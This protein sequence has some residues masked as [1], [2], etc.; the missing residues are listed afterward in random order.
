[1]KGCGVVVVITALVIGVFVGAAIVWLTARGQGPQTTPGVIMESQGEIKA[2]LDS[3]LT[4]VERMAAVLA[5]SAQRGRAGEFVL[6]N[7]LEETGM[8]QHRDFDVQVTTDSARPDVVLNLAGRGRLVIDAKF[9]LD[10]FQ[11]AATAVTEEERRHALAAHARA[12][13][14]HVTELGQRDY[15]SK[16][17]GA[18]NFTVCFV[19]G[20]DLLAAAY[21][22]QPSLFYDAIRVRILIATPATLMAL[23]WGVAYGWQQDA[24]FQQAEVIGKE[25]AELH[26]RL[27]TMV[28]HSQR[29]GGSLNAAVNNYDRFVGSLERYVLPKARK[30][31]DLGILPHGAHIKE[32]PMIGRQGRPVAVERYPVA[33]G[34]D[35]EFEVEFLDEPEAAGEG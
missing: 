4:L 21:E 8:A 29:L 22:E 9:P 12:V 28:E 2:R 13:S 3:A 34:E 35:F 15:P 16:V 31:E 23:L 27:G 24:R 10:D 11:R 19:P 18:I 30:L 17:E 6:E 33:D 25:A 14:R 7:L 5:N 26:K 20:E 1:M 32:V